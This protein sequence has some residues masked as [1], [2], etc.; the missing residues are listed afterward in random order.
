MFKYA[1]LTV[2]RRDT[3][4]SMFGYGFLS[5]SITVSGWSIVAS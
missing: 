5:S 2:A 1:Q 4:A 3:L